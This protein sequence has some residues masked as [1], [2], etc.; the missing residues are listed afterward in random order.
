MPV[1][2]KLMAVVTLIGACHAA[3]GQPGA[4]DPNGGGKPGT[5]PISGIEILVGMGALLGGKKLYDIR[6]RTK[7]SGQ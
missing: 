7:K 3:N 2:R 6:K 1:I 5:V 4:G